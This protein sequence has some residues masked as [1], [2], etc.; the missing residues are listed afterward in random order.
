MRQ[1][2]YV[3]IDT[4]MKRGCKP[5]PKSALPFSALSSTPPKDLSPEEKVVFKMLVATYQP[6]VSQKDV[7]VKVAQLQVIYDHLHQDVEDRGSIYE[8]P[9]G[10]LAKNPAVSL[11]YGANDRIRTLTD[12][13]RD[14]H[15]RRTVATQSTPEDEEYESMR[16]LAEG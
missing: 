6:D 1:L 15:F 3:G 13:L 5:E 12:D 8:L 2:G 10:Y 14:E 16:R 9:N 4:D 11:L 7:V